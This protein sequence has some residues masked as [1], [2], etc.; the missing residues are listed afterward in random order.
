[1]F[2]QVLQVNCHTLAN[3][4]VGNF[5]SSF[6]SILG[7]HGIPNK[8]LGNFIDRQSDFDMKN[9]ANVDAIRNYATAKTLV[10][11]HFAFQT[12][13]CKVISALN[14]PKVILYHNITPPC[15][16][17]SPNARLDTIESFQQ[18]LY[19]AS[20]FPYAWGVSEY[21][22]SQL[23]EIGY[24]RTRVVNYPCDFGKLSEIKP[25]D[26]IAKK[27]GAKNIL[28]VGRIAPN[29]RQKDAIKA[30]YYYRKINPCS[31]LTLVGSYEGE[32]KRELEQLSAELGVPVNIPG[33]IPLDEL[34]AH[35]KNA[36]LFLCMSEH[37]GFCIP[38]IE[39]MFF[40]VPVLAFQSSAVTE[41]VG[42]AGIIFK[43][44]SFSHVAHLMDAILSDATLQ[45]KMKI[46]GRERALC[47][48]K[49]IVSE[50]IRSAI[51][52]YAVELGI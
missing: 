32:S 24:A 37:E 38:L 30:F 48:S 26:K 46:A 18:M 39:A 22:C 51:E 33:K 42:N 47:Y 50:K 28:F 52:D 10:V 15:F 9:W 44:K 35:Y 17:K 7:E 40:G 36:D 27:D 1:M 12:P 29:K 8:L 4:G 20:Y 34:A 3:D 31:E 25:S 5:V 14:C 23:R 45:G 21:N 49:E 6:A 2:E 16:S 19:M 11:F 13:L 43:Q 41:T